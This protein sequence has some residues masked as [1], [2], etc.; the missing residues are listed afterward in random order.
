VGGDLNTEGEEGEG[1]EQEDKPNVLVVAFTFI[2]SFLSS[3]IPGYNP[4]PL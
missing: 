4:P 1:E 2:S 3:I